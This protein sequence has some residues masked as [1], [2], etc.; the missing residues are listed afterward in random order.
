[1]V[2]SDTILK[3]NDV[4]VC[5]LIRTKKCTCQSKPFNVRT[6]ISIDQF[7]TWQLIYNLI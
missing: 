7:A 3:R 2:R 5:L 1:M 4:N 6:A